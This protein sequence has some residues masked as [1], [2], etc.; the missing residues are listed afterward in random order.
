MNNL[1][2]RHR[3]CAITLHKRRWVDRSQLPDGPQTARC[4]IVGKQWQF[5]NNPV[6]TE[7]GCLQGVVAGI[8]DMR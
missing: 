6:A 1:D 7:I 4:A 2:N 5:N 3:A 8:T